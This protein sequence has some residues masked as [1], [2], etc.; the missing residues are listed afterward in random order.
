MASATAS[1]TAPRMPLQP[2]TSRHE[3]LDRRA[4]W[5][6]RRSSARIRYGTVKSQTSRVATT[7]ALTARAYPASSPAE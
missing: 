7:T 5:L 6:G 1:D 2:T 3:A 4:T